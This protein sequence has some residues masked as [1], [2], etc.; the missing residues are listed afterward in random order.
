MPAHHGGAGCVFRY[1]ASARMSQK[2][3]VSQPE[4]FS[5]SDLANHEEI[6]AR[7][8]NYRK[9][10][11]RLRRLRP[12][13]TNPE[14]M[15][16][17]ARPLALVAATVAI[18]ATGAPTASPTDAPTPAPTADISVYFT[19]KFSNIKPQDFSAADKIAYTNAVAA[20][21]SVPNDRVAAVGDGS[22]LRWDGAQDTEF[23]FRVFATSLDQQSLTARSLPRIPTA[24]MHSYSC[25]KA[26]RR[27][28]GASIGN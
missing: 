14:T 9:T 25:R 1:R 3:P 6:Q 5:S 17:L 18:L 23:E 19:L 7:G 27:K 15:M 8:P 26:C 16:G 13:R 4:Q 10:R 20:A 12:D 24:M 28:S 11:A 21:L 22:Q 2:K